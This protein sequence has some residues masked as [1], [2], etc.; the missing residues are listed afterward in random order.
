MPALPPA[1]TRPSSLLVI[2]VCAMALL[3]GLVT[4]QAMSTSPSANPT[5]KMSSTIGLLTRVEH[6]TVFLKTENGVKQYRYDQ[7][8]D[9]E[10]LQL[11]AGA[12]IK[13]KLTLE[14]RKGEQV[15]TAVEDYVEVDPNAPKEAKP[16]TMDD[17]LFGTVRVG[18]T[19]AQVQQLAGPPLGQSE[20]LES[21]A[22]GERQECDL[23]Q[24]NEARWQYQICYTK[25]RVVG[26]AS[27]VWFLTQP[28]AAEVDIASEKAAQ[29]MAKPAADAKPLEITLP[30]SEKVLS[31]LPDE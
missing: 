25:D 8:V 1:L 6:G 16:R 27:G 15:V 2:G 18:M 7:S 24:A 10:H 14:Q 20:T 23:W 28:T 29:K 26:R 9:G 12:R 30:D 19:K 22:G 5:T 31:Y 13:T 4:S 21:A 11:H 3:G 17:A